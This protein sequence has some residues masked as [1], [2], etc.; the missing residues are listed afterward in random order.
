MYDEIYARHAGL[1][2][3]GRGHGSFSD[4]SESCSWELLG[5][6]NHFP[7]NMDMPITNCS[8]RLKVQKLYSNDLDSM[9]YIDRINHSNETGC[10]VGISTYNIGNQQKKN[11]T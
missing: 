10:I 9:A 1:K 8:G 11:E 3:I 2:R 5:L 7:N 4:M 6:K